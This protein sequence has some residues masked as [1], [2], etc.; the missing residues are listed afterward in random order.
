[1]AISHT[2]VIERIARVLAGQRLS[3][4][5]KGDA[6]SVSAEV[7][8][9]WPDY[10]D[11]AIA[12]LRTLREPDAAI[13]KAGN[14]DTWEAMILAALGKDSH[15]AHA[16]SQSAEPPYDPPPPGTDPFNEGP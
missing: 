2:P 4:N 13:A 9:H 10:R 6:A 5:A 12:V 16:G 8:M 15:S 7:D 1:M 3:V 11:D 14:P